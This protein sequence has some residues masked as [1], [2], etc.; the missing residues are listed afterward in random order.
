M[1]TPHILRRGKLTAMFSPYRE[2]QS[3][4][5]GELP[6]LSASWRSKLGIKVRF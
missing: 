4:R 3:D 6:G 2:L 5:V 1:F